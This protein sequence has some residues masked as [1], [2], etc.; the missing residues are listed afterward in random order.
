MIF[1]SHINEDSAP[2]SYA[3]KRFEY[4]QLDCIAGSGERVIALLD[5]DSIYQL[6]IID[7]NPAALFLTEIKLTALKYLNVSEYLSFI[8]FHNSESEERIR[9][10]RAIVP[11]LHSDCQDFW[12]NNLTS[13]GKGII[14]AGHFEKF[15]KRVT[16]ILKMIYGKRIERILRQP[17][18][19]WSGYD[20]MAW[21]ILCKFFAYKFP[22]LVLGNRDPAFIHGAC[23]LKYI[24]D[25]LNKSFLRIQQDQSAFIHLLFHG[26]LNKMEI[27]SLPMSF[28]SEH[29]QKVKNNISKE[30]LKMTF[31][32]KDLLQY[33]TTKNDTTNGH[34]FYSISDILSFVS[35]QYILNLIERIRHCAKDSKK[36]VVL[37]SFV[38][39]RLAISDV[40]KLVKKNDHFEDISNL[41]KTNLYQVL[42]TEIHGNGI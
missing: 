20:K 18:E 10:F 35:P 32:H 39:N 8:G 11:Y 4:N 15:L 27:S 31:I 29:L 6:N 19:K 26:N 17:M 9:I 34:Q 22:Y 2:E 36:G 3:L 37:R 38:R 30:S 24:P 13:I 25:A 33:L 5:S 21:K 23:E 16:T 1:Y 7:S 28:N 42:L 40:E 41:D 14:Y 12:S